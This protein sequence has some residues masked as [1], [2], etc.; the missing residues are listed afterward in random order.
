[1]EIPEDIRQQLTSVQRE[2]KE[3]HADVKWVR[4][5]S[6]HLTLKFLG[7]ID[8]ARVDDIREAIGPIAK[9]TAPF[10]VV[11]K[12]LGCFP[13]LHQPR[14]IWAGLSDTNGEMVELQKSI[15]ESI[16]ALGFRPEGKPFSPHLTLGR[17]RSGRGKDDLV[18]QVR[19][20]GDISLGDFSVH[21]VV[22]FRSELHPSGARY[23]KLWEVALSGTS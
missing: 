9:D 22:Q 2:L 17:V 21:T 14:V 15:E 20:L 10:Q 23:T 6:M 12:G 1:M 19:R 18:S 4:P 16:E 11:V 7:E 3:S 8:P 13:R 5:D